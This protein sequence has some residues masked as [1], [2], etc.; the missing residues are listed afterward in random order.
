M[1]A[2]FSTVC[3]WRHSAQIKRGH[4]PIPAHLHILKG[5]VQLWQDMHSN[6]GREVAGSTQTHNIQAEP[7]ARWYH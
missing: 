2:G 1:G 3:A 6:G 4:F 5:P 7:D